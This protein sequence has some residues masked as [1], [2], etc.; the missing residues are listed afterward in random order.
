MTIVPLDFQ[1]LNTDWFGYGLSYHL[2]IFNFYFISISKLILKWERLPI[3]NF[4]I[5]RKEGKGYFFA[6]SVANLPLEFASR[7]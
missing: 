1:V 3:K 2:H 5:D 4:L 7:L 6:N